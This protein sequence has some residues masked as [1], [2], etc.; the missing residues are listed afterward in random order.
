MS[1]LNDKTS[2]LLITV[3]AILTVAVGVQSIAMAKLYNKVN[4]GTGTEKTT[5]FIEPKEDTEDYKVDLQSDNSSQNAQSLQFDWNMDNWDPFQEMQA[6]QNHINQMFGNAFNKF[7]HSDAFMDLFDKYS[8]SPNINVEDKGK[9]YLI[10]VDAPGVE[11]SNLNIKIEGQVLTISGTLQN[12]TKKEEKGKML[13]QER[14]TG[15]FHRLVTLP[16]PVKEDEMTTENERGI[17]RIKLPKEEE[18]KKK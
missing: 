6:M 8:F 5:V 12:E 11:D 9:Y 16:S 15:S 3:I 10:T 4:K 2:R 14:R 7:N 1:T 18:Q 13:R 17:I